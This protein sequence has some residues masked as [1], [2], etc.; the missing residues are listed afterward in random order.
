MSHNAERTLVHHSG[1][2]VLGQPPLGSP[3]GT[4]GGLE[5]LA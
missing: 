4:I 2:T 1:D 3:G 5:N